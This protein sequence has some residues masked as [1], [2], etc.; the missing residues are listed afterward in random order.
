M[1]F[2][3]IAAVCA[4]VGVRLK[5]ADLCVPRIVGSSCVGEMEPM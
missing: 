1:R 5:C 2:N 4:A 3:R